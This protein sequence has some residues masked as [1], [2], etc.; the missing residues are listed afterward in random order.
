MKWEGRLKTFKRR[1]TSWR[2]KHGRRR[3]RTR[4][5]QTSQRPIRPNV[6]ETSRKTL[7]GRRAAR[8]SQ[9]IPKMD[10]LNLSCRGRSIYLYLIYLLRGTSKVG[11]RHCCA[12]G[13]LCL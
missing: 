10:S 6:P 1:K 8:M 4:F 9:R 5:G 13:S 11:S 7:I 3:R 2:Y 12:L